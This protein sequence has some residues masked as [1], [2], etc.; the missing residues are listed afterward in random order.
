MRIIWQKKELPTDSSPG[1]DSFQMRSPTGHTA[2]VHRVPKK[3]LF[4]RFGTKA[5]RQEIIT[6]FLINPPFLLIMLVIYH[7]N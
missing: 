3:F 5:I 7:K 4:F 2:K 6:I 1:K